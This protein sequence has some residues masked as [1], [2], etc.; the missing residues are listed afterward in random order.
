MKNLLFA[1]IV[2]A[3]MMAMTSSASAQCGYRSYGYH[4]YYR[5]APVV[6]WPGYGYGGYGPVYSGY[7]GYANPWYGYRTSYYGGYPVYRSAYYGGGYGGY[8][9]GYPGGISV[10]VGGS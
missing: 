7:R 4:T 1:A 8:G 6:T 2:C 3:A 10:V 5:P 9:W